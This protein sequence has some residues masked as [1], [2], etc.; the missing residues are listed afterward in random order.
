MTKSIFFFRLDANQATVIVGLVEIVS[1]L[2]YLFL[3][4]S[5][6]WEMSNPGV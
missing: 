4:L 3:I 2:N 1:Y 6:E 5:Q